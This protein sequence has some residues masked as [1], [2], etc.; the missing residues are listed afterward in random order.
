MRRRVKSSICEKWIAW[1]LIVCLCLSNIGELG[2]A[3]AQEEAQ[4]AEIVA[5]PA[6][7]A[8]SSRMRS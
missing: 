2:A 7:E 5:L 3:F 4:E 8:G 6:S 1:F